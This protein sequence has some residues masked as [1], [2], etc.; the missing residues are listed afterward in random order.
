MKFPYHSDDISPITL[1][2]LRRLARSYT[3]L[4]TTL[5]LL[6]VHIAAFCACAF[7][8]DN[9]DSE[10]SAMFWAAATTQPVQMLL[11][12]IVFLPGCMYVSAKTSDEM[13]DIAFSPKEILHGYW[14]VGIILGCY[15]TTLALPFV[16]LSYVYGGQL[17]VSLWA[18]FSNVL[19]LLVLSLVYFSW[20]AKVRSSNVMWLVAVFLYFFGAAHVMGPILAEV[21]VVSRFGGVPGGA[22]APIQYD[23]LSW[24]CFTF[25]QL[26]GLAVVAYR[27]S[28]LH[29]ENRSRGV[30]VAVLINLGIYGLIA[31]SMFAVWA[32]LRIWHVI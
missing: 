17:L 31:T 10:M 1:R 14:G 15:Y 29:L 9:I 23:E 5:L 27:L 8:G 16:A 12:F 2:Q 28:L 24:V 21:F 25:F 19:S 20:L 7:F 32:A 4:W 3:L 26:F 22:F 6:A 30:G 13:L 18:L 11:S